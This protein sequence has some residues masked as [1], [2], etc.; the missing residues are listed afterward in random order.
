M[1][2]MCSYSLYRSVYTYG[3]TYA[4]ADVLVM[5]AYPYA[6]PYMYAN[7]YLEMTRTWRISVQQYLLSAVSE[8]WDLRLTL[9]MH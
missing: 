4:Y 6:Y 5:S 7:S 9:A 1:L 2:S 3:Y 8:P